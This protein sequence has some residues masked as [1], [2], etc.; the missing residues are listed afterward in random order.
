MNIGKEQL[1]EMLNNE[2]FPRSGKYDPEWVLRNE[3]GPNALWLMEWLCEEMD[4]KPGRATVLS[5]R[6]RACASWIWDA[7]GP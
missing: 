7:A 5:R 2:Q 6:V 1:R 3:M 4:L